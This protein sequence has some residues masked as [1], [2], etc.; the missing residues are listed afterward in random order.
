MA[1]PMNLR[2]VHGADE[3]EAGDELGTNAHSEITMFAI[4]DGDADGVE[5]VLEVSPDREHWATPTRL[6]EDD[7]FEISADEFSEDPDS[8]VQTA[9]IFQ[10]GCHFEHV[11][12][13]VVEPPAE[14]S[15]TVWIAMG[16]WGGPG[17]SSTIHPSEAR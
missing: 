2:S 1:R 7:G 4:V 14:G 11:R 13:R 5:V 8:G 9:A 3:A 15:V 17:R 10:S 16:G 12:A 6:N